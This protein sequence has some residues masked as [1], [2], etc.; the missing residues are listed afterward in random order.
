MTK[1]KA[2]AS[3]KAKAGKNRNDVKGSAESDETKTSKEA[4]ESHKAYLT[5]SIRATAVVTAKMIR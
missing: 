1:Q 5:M 3:A 4:S 2:A